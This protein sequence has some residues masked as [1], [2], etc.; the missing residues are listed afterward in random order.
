MPEG[1]TEPAAVKMRRST[2]IDLPV[3]PTLPSQLLVRRAQVEEAGA[4][5]ALC[6]RAYTAEVWE[7][8]GTKRELFHDNTVRAVLVVAD[9][10]QLLAT[11]SLQ[12]N[13]AEPESGQVRWVAT[14]L[15]WRRRGLA[16][17]LVVRLL[18][19]AKK[20]GCKAVY[21]RTTTDLLSAITLYL[22]LGFE[23]VK[24]NESDRDA[25]EEVTTLLSSGA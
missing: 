7:P 6:G 13:P 1:S 12:V 18:E 11:A 23:P 17:A 25:W 9:A 21:L 4:L 5:S 24:S 15:E 22:Q 2:T 14:E 8:E 16:R 19:L 3:V 20:E 10:D